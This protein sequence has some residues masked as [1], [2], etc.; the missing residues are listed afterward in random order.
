MKKQIIGI[1]AFSLVVSGT[2]LAQDAMTTKS[3]KSKYT[4]IGPVMGMGNSWVSNMTNTLKPSAY[5]G[6]GILYSRY[7]HWGFGGLLIASHEGYSREAYR[8]QNTYVN[9]IDP[10]YLRF[11]PRAYYFFGDYGNNVRPKIYAGPSLA[12]KV[13]EDQYLQEPET[14]RELTYT[15][16]TGE[17]FTNWDFGV[18]AGAGVNIKIARYMWLNLDAD[19]YHGLINVTNE[20]NKNRTLRANA[21]LMIGI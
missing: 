2:A 8:Y 18:N 6:M 9:T 14:F 3:Q 10:T 12:Y 17:M 4:S 20:N 5:L 11:T 13:R 1:I 15:R 19:Y 21:G 7:E 16:P